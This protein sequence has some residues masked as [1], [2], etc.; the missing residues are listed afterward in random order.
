MG[1]RAV[2]LPRMPPTVYC[3]LVVG[4]VALAL[5]LGFAFRAPPFV[6]NDSLS[7]LLPGLDLARG[8]EFAPILKRPPLY[9]AFIGGVVVLFGEEL[10]VLMLV[11]HLLGVVTA[12]F[13][14]GIGQLVFGRAAGLLA[15]L[16][17]ALSGSLI[18]TEHYLMSET[19][20]GALLAATLLVFLAGI[21]RPGIV[22][23]A[24]AG[25]LLGLAALTRPIAQ[26]AALLLP[27]SLLVLL[28]RR[29]T[30]LTYG[31]V[32]LGCFAVT[33]LPWMVRNRAVQG[34]FSIAGGLGEGL[35]VR[36]I[37]YGQQFDFREP[38]GGE[39]DR[40]VA[41]ARRIYREEARDGSAFELARRLREELGVT[42]AQADGL[43]REIA[44]GAIL[45]Q[46]GY[47]LQGT[48]EM[49]ARTFAGRPVRL[50]QDWTPWRNINWGNTR[51]DHLLPTP[52][53][54]ED[55]AFPIAE[56]LATL[57]DPA[58]FALPLAVLFAIGGLSGLAVGLRPALLLAVLVLTL[59]LASTA[60]V[61]IEWR[62]R[63]PLDPLIN[64]LIAGGLVVLATGLAGRV[65]RLRVVPPLSRERP[66]SERRPHQ[67][68]PA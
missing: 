5:R 55:R 39:A 20:F 42:E 68:V 8:F 41:R 13:A 17:T 40:L 67:E 23:F 44:L 46:P 36:T 58:R 14:F 31:A 11:Q 59:L 7:Y 53:P 32:L 22:P 34:T 21:R 24:L 10:R 3:L 6:T 27:L 61:G 51:A 66:S 52:T 19:L 33:I 63:Y 16:L 45:R 47:F 56:R 28:P 65:R 15:G 43:M 60:L 64:V 9:P 62:Y 54:A 50:R 48:A 12:L 57:Y 2:P 26:L 29:R 38:P 49:F 37:R 1:G 35:A 25:V 30:A 18:V 4:G